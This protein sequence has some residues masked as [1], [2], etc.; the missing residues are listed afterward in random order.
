MIAGA[1]GVP[2]GVARLAVGVGR[3][4]IGVAHLAASVLGEFPGRARVACI[5]QR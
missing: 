3:V 4:A 5:P 1:A 2:T